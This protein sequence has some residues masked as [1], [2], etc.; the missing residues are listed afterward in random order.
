MNSCPFCSTPCGTKWCPYN[1]TESTE[2]SLKRED[3]K[4]VIFN[5][6]ESA[7]HH[8]DA[9][10]KLAD[11]IL[12]EIEKAGILPPITFLSKLKASDNSWEQE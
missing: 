10:E 6:L 12:S 9:N 8:P 5:K 2:C 4:K 1:E 11:E 3:M 7:N